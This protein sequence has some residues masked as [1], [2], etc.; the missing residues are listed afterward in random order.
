MS[1]FIVTW[2][3]ISDAVA[4]MASDTMTEK[5]RNQLGSDLIRLNVAAFVHRY[6]HYPEDVEEAN[7]VAESAGHYQHN[8]PAPSPCPW[9]RVKSAECLAYQCAE[10]PMVQHPLRLRLEKAFRDALLSLSGENDEE[11]ARSRPEY[12]RAKWTRVDD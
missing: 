9:Q 8:N 5:E 2:E 6:S 10:G 7:R 12:R 1:C 3:T 4:V 11:L